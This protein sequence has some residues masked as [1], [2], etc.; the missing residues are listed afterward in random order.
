LS[1]DIGVLICLFQFLSEHGGYA[2]AYTAS[3][4]TNYHFDVAP[5]HLDGAL[6]RFVF[7]VLQSADPTTFW[8]LILRFAQFFISPLFTASATEREVNAV[9]HENDKNLQMDNWRLNQLDK[10]T[11]DPSHPYSKFNTGLHAL[12]SKEFP[13]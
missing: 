3:E 5:D 13:R 9:N 10:S 4:H 2:N 11:S 1:K 12:F 7:C 8:C 6:D